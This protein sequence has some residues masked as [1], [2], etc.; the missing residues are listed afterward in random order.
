VNDAMPRTTGTK[1]ATALLPSACG[2]ARLDRGLGGASVGAVAGAAT[3]GEVARGAVLGAT[4]G[5]AVGV[6]TD[7]G[8]IDLGEPVWRRGPKA[9]FPATKD[10]GKVEPV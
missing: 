2:E 9:L 8:Q 3:G 7:K 6:L 5:A 10:E 1:G 4:V